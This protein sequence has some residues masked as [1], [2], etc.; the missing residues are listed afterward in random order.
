MSKKERKHVWLREGDYKA[1]KHLYPQIAPSAAIRII[2]S[3]HI[4]NKDILKDNTPEIS[5]EL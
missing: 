4:D 2:I 3:Q 1:L 5:I